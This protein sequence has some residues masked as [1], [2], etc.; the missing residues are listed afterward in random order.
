MAASLA[1]LREVGCARR[2]PGHALQ[3]AEDQSHREYNCEL[4]RHHEINQ[5]TLHLEDSIVRIDDTISSPVSETGGP[6]REI[7]EPV[8]AAC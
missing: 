2:A 4:S 6:P 8:K 5:Q 1:Q 7:T 3:L